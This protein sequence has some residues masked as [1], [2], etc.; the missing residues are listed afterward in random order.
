MTVSSDEFTLAAD[1][2]AAS[3]DQWR[4]LVLG[5][6]R[7][8]GAV[9][10]DGTD[11]PR[12]PEELL[13]TTTYDGVTVAPLHTAEDPLPTTGLPGLAPFV[14][15]SRPQGA[16]VGGWDVRQRHAHPDPKVTREAVL[17]DLEN[18]V[19][20]LW[21]AVGDGGLPATAL[22]HVLAEVYLDLAGVVLDGGTTGPAAAEALLELARS[23]GADPA[24]LRGG[25]GLDPLGLAARTGGE[26]DVAIATTWATRCAT[27][28]GGLRALTVDGLP[29]HEA[30]GSDTEELGC[31]LAAG[32]AYLRALTDGGLDLTTALRQLEFRYA[33]TADQFLTIA[34]LRAARRLWARVGEVCGAEESDRAQRQHAVTSPAMMTRRD[35]WVNMLRTTVAC[36]AAGVGG[37]DAVTVLPFDTALGLSDDFARRIARNTQSLLLEESHVARVIDPAGGSWYV[38]RLTEDLASAAWAWF[39]EIERA[40]GLARAL[41]DGLVARR[42]AATAARRADEL[43]HRRDPVTGVS[44]FPNLDEE[45]PARTPAPPAPG[46]GLPRL[47]YAQDFEALRDRVDAHTATTGSRPAVFLA[48][49]GPIAAHTAR[50]TFAANLFQAAGLATPTSGPATDP[51]EIAAA[52]TA[53]GSTVACLCGAAKT[54]A[55][56]AAPV[57]RALT[58]AGAQ[59]VWLAGKPGDRAASD[60]A[61]GVDDYVFTGCD[62]LGILRTTLHDLGV[63]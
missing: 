11:T 26:P 31:T 46:G 56:L 57:A 22:P 4:E 61:A 1:F 2:P 63:A 12:E 28:L 60:A 7:K 45:L 15:G 58:E 32:L 10:P 30:G 47:R 54:Y 38:E 36:F 3:R 39:T 14:R 13:A 5:V 33:A 18:G 19:S 44:E 25:L 43:A 16:V 48:T 35:P 37:A 24:Q 59:R 41:A 40:G 8:S 62:A 52:F 55:E 34:K 23:R 29:Y 42:L 50:A 21:L 53:S 6:L 51:A 17:A 9:D 49:L 27:E 20:S